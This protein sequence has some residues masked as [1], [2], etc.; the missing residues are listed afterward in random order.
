MLKLAV[1][2]WFAFVL[3]AEAVNMI[4][5]MITEKDRKSTWKEDALASFISA[6]VHAVFLIWMLIRWWI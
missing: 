6:M 1:T 2:V 3:C 5:R 4:Y